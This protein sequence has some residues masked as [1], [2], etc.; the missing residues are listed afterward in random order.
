MLKEMSWYH[1]ASGEGCAVV[2]IRRKGG[3][4][5]GGAEL[6]RTR[7]LLRISRSSLI[8]FAH[9]YFQGDVME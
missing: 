9:G 3:N 1:G 8:N 4:N 6:E 7:E 5:C 2:C